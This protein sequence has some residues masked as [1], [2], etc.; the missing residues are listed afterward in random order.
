M[1][2]ADYLDDLAGYTATQVER[3]C[4][5]FRKL[6]DS[7]FF[8][9]SGEL[10]VLLSGRSSFDMPPCRLPTFRAPLALTGPRGKM[11]SVADVLRDTGH[12]AAAEKWE[13]RSST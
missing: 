1:V 5:Q 7:K 11:K 13:A 12:A 2:I 8:P 9:K 4:M 3:A 6:P 10:L